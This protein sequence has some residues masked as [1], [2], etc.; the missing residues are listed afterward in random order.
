MAGGSSHRKSAGQ[1]FPMATNQPVMGKN[2]YSDQQHRQQTTSS[3]F[4]P[5]LRRT[6][7]DPPKIAAVF[8]DNGDSGNVPTP[9][10]QQP[11][12]QQQLK[13]RKIKRRRRQIH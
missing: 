6:M 3:A 13:R 10:N 8:S 7:I 12:Q 2:S 4:L 11:Q 9:T 5:K 1:A